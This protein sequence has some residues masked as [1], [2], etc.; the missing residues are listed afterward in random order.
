MLIKKLD[1][2]IDNNLNLFLENLL[3]QSKWKKKY[4]RHIDQR[5]GLI[6]FSTIGR[7]C[8]REERNNYYIWDKKTKERHIICEEIQK[9]FPLLEASIGGQISIDIYPK[10]KNK[11]QVLDEINGPIVF[12]G[13]KCNK[14]GNDYPIVERLELEDTKR[15]YTVYNVQNFNETWNILKTI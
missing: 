3:N 4:N 2:L 12:F 7:D 14:G 15:K 11:A 6:N 5:I 10:G 9:E 8:P 13:D 1:F